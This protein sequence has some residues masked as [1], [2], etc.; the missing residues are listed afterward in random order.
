MIVTCV[1]SAQ[2]EEIAMA[3]KSKAAI[4]TFVNLLFIVSLLG[5]KVNCTHKSYLVSG[6]KTTRIPS[7]GLPL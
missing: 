7:G 6:E 5:Q 3:T 1:L 2:V 4:K